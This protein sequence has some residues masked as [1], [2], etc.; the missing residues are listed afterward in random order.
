[1]TQAIGAIHNVSYDGVNLQIY[2]ANKGLL[3][4]QVIQ[5]EFMG[6]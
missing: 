3:G 2:H 4:H 1:M 6:A 5:Q